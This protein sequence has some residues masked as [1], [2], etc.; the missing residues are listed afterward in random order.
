MTSADIYNMT[1]AQQQQGR[2]VLMTFP[3]HRV[4]WWAHVPYSSRQTFGARR[5]HKSFVTFY[6]FSD[7]S[8]RSRGTWLTWIHKECIRVARKGFSGV[9]S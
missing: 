9:L 6:A 4:T 7:R 5:A 2:T 3:T 1:A 8:W